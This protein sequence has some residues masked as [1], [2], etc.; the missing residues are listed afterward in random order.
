LYVKTELLQALLYFST[1]N[2]GISLLLFIP[3][4]FSTSIYFLLTKG[5]FSAFHKIKSDEIWN[6]HAGSSL[7]IYWF[8]FDNVLK[9]KRL[10]PELQLGD[11]L[12]QVIPAGCWFAARTENPD[13]FTL[14]GCTV[15]PGFDFHDFE[16]ARRET[17]LTKYADYREIILEFTGA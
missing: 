8:D 16:I 12:Q 10:G 3:R 15:A 4:C 14:A 1:P 6:Y 7:L 5:E 13:S 11:A 2:S 9:I 17:L